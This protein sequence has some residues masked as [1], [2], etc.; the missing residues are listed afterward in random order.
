[1]SGASLLQTARTRNWRQDGADVFGK[2]SG[3]SAGGF[4]GGYWLKMVAPRGG[5]S[6]DFH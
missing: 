4:S 1:M 2:I 6:G 5:I 3:W